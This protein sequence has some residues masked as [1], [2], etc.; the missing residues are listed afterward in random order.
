MGVRKSKK[1]SKSKP[2]QPK[3]I[4]TGYSGKPSKHELG[5]RIH[6]LMSRILAPMKK[7]S[8]K[9]KDV[10]GLKKKKVAVKKQKTIKNPMFDETLQGVAKKKGFG[11]SFREKLQ[12]AGDNFN[13]NLSKIEKKANKSKFIGYVD[14]K[15][16]KYITKSKKSD[17]RLTEAELKQIKKIPNAGA[18]N[19]VINLHRSEFTESELADFKSKMTDLDHKLYADTEKYDPSLWEELVGELS[20]E[21]TMGD[22][23]VKDY[24]NEFI[25]NNT[26]VRGFEKHENTLN[27]IEE[28]FIKGDKG[29]KVDQVISNIESQKELSKADLESFKSIMGEFNKVVYGDDSKVHSSSLWE[30]F[31]GKL[32]SYHVLENG[33]FQNY[34]DRVLHDYE[35]MSYNDI[36]DRFGENSVVTLLNIAERFDKF[37]PKWTI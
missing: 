10:T 24:V 14:R 33:S 9:K 11:R 23:S 12:A 19:E 27:A 18:I 30:D 1:T 13:K 22:K 35:M 34:I 16:D 37:R 2:K 25:Q 29:D 5:L 6:M 26:N 31:L 28:L 4:S 15:I 36:K 20:N 8:R 21:Y 32:G 3:I 7:L 17:P